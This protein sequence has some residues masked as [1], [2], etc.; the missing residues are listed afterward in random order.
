MNYK[1]GLKNKT[2]QCLLCSKEF[3]AKKDCLTRDQKYCSKE[4][5]SKSQRGKKISRRQLE[6]L[7]KGRYKGKKIGGWRWSKES[8]DRVKGKKSLRWQGGKTKRN[9]KIRNSWKMRKWKQEVLKR[10][11]Y[12][13][14]EC[15][16]R[17][18]KLV[19]DHIKPFCLYPKLRFNLNNGRTICKKCDLKSKTYGGRAT[20]N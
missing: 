10:D 5:F 12:T 14:Q 17:G 15:G 2:K 11:N 4:C 19:V 9:Y 13:C 18:V 3:I 7:K 1:H 8:R 20:K 6:S 16:K